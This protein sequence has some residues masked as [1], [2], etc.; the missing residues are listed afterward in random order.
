MRIFSVSYDDVND[1]AYPVLRHRMKMNF[2]AIASRVS[3]DDVI[4]MILSELGK[5]YDLAPRANADAANSRSEVSEI[6]ASEINA[7]EQI[8]F[9]V[10]RIRSKS[11]P[12][13]TASATSAM[14]CCVISTICISSSSA[15]RRNG[16]KHCGE[17]R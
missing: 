10:A 9:A 8:L 6:S 17:R 12:L 5:K 11:S 3:A 13:H 7:D 14:V 15:G 1:L 16:H 2:E 4:K